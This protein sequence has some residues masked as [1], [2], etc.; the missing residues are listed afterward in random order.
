MVFLG[1]LEKCVYTKL[2]H[3]QEHCCNNATIIIL[4]STLFIYL[5]PQR[6]GSIGFDVRRSAVQNCFVFFSSFLSSSFLLDFAWIR[7]IGLHVAPKPAPATENREKIDIIWYALQPKRRAEELVMASVSF[8]VN[9]FFFNLYSISRKLHCC[10]LFADFSSTFL[11]CLHFF[12]L[13]SPR[14]FVLVYIRYLT[15]G[16]ILLLV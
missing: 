16:C 5:I 15:A 4:L 13:V 10:S 14:P 12:S 6:F 1:S 3:Y 8:F 11:N 9:V 2:S 7:A